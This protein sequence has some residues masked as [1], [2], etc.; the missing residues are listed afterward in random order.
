MDQERKLTTD[1]QLWRRRQDNFDCLQPSLGLVRNKTGES[2]NDSAT[3]GRQLCLLAS[4]T[5]KPY[6]IWVQK[7]TNSSQHWFP[8]ISSGKA[9]EIWKL[10]FLN[11]QVTPCSHR[12]CRLHYRKGQY[13]CRKHTGRIFLGKSEFLNSYLKGGENSSFALER[14]LHK[15]LCQLPVFEW[16]ELKNN[17]IYQSFS[18]DRFAVLGDDS[19][20]FPLCLFAGLGRAGPSLFPGEGPGIP[21]DGSGHIRHHYPSDH[22]AWG[23]VRLAGVTERSSL[24]MD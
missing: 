17:L 8:Q 3:W 18:T 19:G 14:A 15:D 5:P 12:I 20:V 2:G 4:H 10:E 6:N 7:T 1:G 11:T 16:S 9:H 21:Q 13:N 23:W 24:D 22:Q